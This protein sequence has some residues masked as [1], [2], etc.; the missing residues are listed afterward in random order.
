[1][2]QILIIVVIILTCCSVPDSSKNETP[3]FIKKRIKPHRI[4]PGLWQCDDIPL[5]G[6]EDHECNP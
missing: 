3:D 2:K 5:I 4:D 1:M 6:E